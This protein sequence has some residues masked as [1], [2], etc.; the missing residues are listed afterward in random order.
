MTETQ[1]AIAEIA[2]LVFMLCTTI[3]VSILVGLFA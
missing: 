3:V 1:A 2:L